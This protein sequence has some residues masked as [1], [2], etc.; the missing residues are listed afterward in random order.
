MKTQAAA[1]KGC[2]TYLMFLTFAFLAMCLVSCQPP[3][4]PTFPTG[5]ADDGPTAE[6]QPL[7]DT[8]PTAD[9][10]PTIV[11]FPQD[12]SCP[13]DVGLSDLALDNWLLMFNPRDT[14]YSLFDTI[15]GQET[16]L[17]SSGLGW[18]V[19]PT[20]DRI[21]YNASSGEVLR[22]AGADGEILESIDIQPDWAGPSWISVT[23]VLFTKEPPEPYEVLA[24]TI[25]LDLQSRVT[26]ELMPTFPGIDN[27]TS[28]D[29]VRH[30]KTR[31]V[32]SPDMSYVVYP[33]I[34][35]NSYWIILW[36]VK[37]AAEIARLPAKFGY[38]SDPQWT[39]DG[40]HVIVSAISS[41]S[42]GG[43]PSQ[44][45]TPEPTEVPKV[46]DLFSVS[47]NGEIERLTGV[48][49]ANATDTFG[50]SL[51]LDGSMVAFWLKLESMTSGYQLATLNLEDA[52]QTKWCIFA[53]SNQ[54]PT[55][56]I[57]SS[58]GDALILTLDRN[59]AGS[60]RSMIVDIKDNQ[61]AQLRY[62]GSDI[63]RAWMQGP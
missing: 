41:E 46:S 18:S 1:P 38:G 37:H 62:P 22:V 42:V 21:A 3:Q 25:A 59:L 11:R 20:Y 26:T 7:A 54:R 58:T 53:S 51:S 29:W 55:A 48:A 2:S 4:V 5:K 28:I 61:V 24:P 31:A 14:S 35:D 44:A 52:L 27:V 13:T 45:E 12:E 47:T 19:S 36:D 34:L 23:T 16:D 10:T 15:S 33:A 49:S 60:V 56:P 50:Y 63:P 17:F 43:I 6:I 57:W 39:A 40:N 9:A 8:V 30:Q 32:Y